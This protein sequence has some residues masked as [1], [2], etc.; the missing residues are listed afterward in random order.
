MLFRLPSGRSLNSESNHG[1]DFFADPAH[2]LKALNGS[3]NNFAEPNN[4]HSVSEYTIVT[5]AYNISDRMFIM[6]VSDG[7]KM[8]KSNSFVKEAKPDPELVFPFCLP[9]DTKPV[10][11]CTET[12]C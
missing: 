1:R 11:S 12:Y 6:L 8:I 3:K 5:S 7:W 9:L 2:H 10:V 4:L